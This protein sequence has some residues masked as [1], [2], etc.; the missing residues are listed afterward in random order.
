LYPDRVKKPAE[1]NRP[2]KLRSIYVAA[3]GLTLLSLSL[4][5]CY[6]G[7]QASTN[8]QAT[9]PSG[10]GNTLRAGQMTV[11]NA[12]VVQ[13]EAGNATVLMRITNQGLESDTLMAAVVGEQPATIT[14]GP[15]EI[16]PGE[17]ISFAWDATHFVNLPGLNATMSS[18]VPLGLQFAIAGITETDVL[19]VP[20][21]GIY[22]DIKP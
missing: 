8:V 18:Y 4:T 22:A 21:T 19:V 20:P 5:G 1:I 17:S 2:V 7:Q 12:T 6:N 13:D 15:V 14:P 16:A 10:N 11:D 3:A 9:Q